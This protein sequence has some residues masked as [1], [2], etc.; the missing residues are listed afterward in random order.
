MANLGIALIIGGLTLV[1]GSVIQF[2]ELQNL[3]N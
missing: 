1:C 2:G 3:S